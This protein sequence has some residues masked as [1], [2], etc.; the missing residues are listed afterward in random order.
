MY[1]YEISWSWNDDYV[2]IILTNEKSFSNDEF[3]NIVDRAVEFA[4]GKLFDE[5]HKKSS[6]ERLQVGFCR[7][8][9]ISKIILDC[10]KD[11]GFDEL[12][13]KS[14]I[15]YFGMYI[16]RR[17]LPKK[18]YDRFKNIC[19]EELVNKM[20]DHNEKVEKQ[21]FEKLDTQLFDELEG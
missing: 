6:E 15:D 8:D 12:E 19:G 7:W 17:D 4:F 14:H 2:P 16:A 13:I 21:L 1:C 3:K 10:L 5:D 18:E 11:H 20:V 9:E